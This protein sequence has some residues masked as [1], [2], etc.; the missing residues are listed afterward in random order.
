M[1]TAEAKKFKE[2]VFRETQ[3][4]ARLQGFEYQTGRRVRVTMR[5]VFA[6]VQRDIANGEKLAVDSIS[7]ALG[8]NDR[9]VDEI[10][11]YRD[12]GEKGE[13]SCQVVLELI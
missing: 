10:H 12:K 9:F 3:V 8:F 4:Q 13:N 6:N 5:F 1:P 11:L 7:L 2:F